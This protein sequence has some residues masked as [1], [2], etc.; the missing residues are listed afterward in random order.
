M[1]FSKVKEFN[2]PEGSVKELSIGNKVVWQKA[3]ES[4]AFKFKTSS[5]RAYG[6][7]S[8][9][10]Y[11]SIITNYLNGN[12]LGYGETYEVKSSDKLVLHMDAPGVTPTTIANYRTNTMYINP[13]FY[14]QSAEIKLILTH[15]TETFWGT[16]TSGEANYMALFFD[17][18]YVPPAP[19]VGI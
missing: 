18:E 1:D 14:G 13:I 19:A 15:D 2:I 12:K 5:I 10:S 16:Y 6:P 7:G 17:P 3:E 4:P 9:E 8:P 11:K